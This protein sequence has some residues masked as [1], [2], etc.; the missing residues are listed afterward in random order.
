M[1]RF[2]LATVIVL[3][4]FGGGFAQADEDAVLD[5]CQLVGPATCTYTAARSGS[6]L[7]TGEWSVEVWWDGECQAGAPNWVRSSVADQ[8]IEGVAAAWEGSVAA[9]S[10]VIATAGAPGSVLLVGNVA[11]IPPVPSP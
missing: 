2:M 5:G 7:A 3:A 8:N 11:G 9:G 4:A 10:C 1:K 6:I